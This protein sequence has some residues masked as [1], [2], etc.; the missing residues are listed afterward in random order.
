MELAEGRRFRISHTRFSVLF[1]SL[2]YWVC[3]A[4]NIDKLAQWFPHK[5]G[6]DFVALAA[7]LLA[8]QCLFLVFFVLLAHRWTI[9]PLA[10]LLLAGS[11][12]ATYYIAKYDV[13]I[14]K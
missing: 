13:A 1:C 2:V 10:I 3:N 4:L 12:A 7:Y 5:G 8:G 6:I 11:A 14:D 9:K